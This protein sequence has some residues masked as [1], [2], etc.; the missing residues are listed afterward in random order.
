MLGDFLNPRIVLILQEALIRVNFRTAAGARPLQTCS[1]SSA[2]LNRALIMATATG[3]PP[4]RPRA[5]MKG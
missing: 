1:Y 2:S 5:A 4:L 3:V